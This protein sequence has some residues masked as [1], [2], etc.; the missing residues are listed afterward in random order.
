MLLNRHLIENWAML[1]LP[2]ADMKLG[3][4]E[5]FWDMAKARQDL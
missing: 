1:P 3:G 5:T 2:F 4:D